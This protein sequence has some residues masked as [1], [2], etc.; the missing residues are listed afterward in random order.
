ML[1]YLIVVWEGISEFVAGCWD[2]RKQSTPY[3]ISA[4][5]KKKNPQWRDVKEL[6]VD[7]V[8]DKQHVFSQPSRPTSGSDRSSRF[9]RGQSN[10]SW[11]QQT[12]RGLGRGAGPHRT[13]LDPGD[14]R[15]AERHWNDALPLQP[16]QRAV[17]DPRGTATAFNSQ[18]WACLGEKLIALACL[19]VVMLFPRAA[20]SWTLFG[21]SR[22]AASCSHL[23]FWT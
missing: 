15:M 14:V 19:I 21:H 23:G 18:Q 17:S 13:L 11:S 16:Q 8:C 5:K 3:V 22:Q 9:K 2:W 6:L 20:L 1:L 4:K 12:P 7:D 10:G